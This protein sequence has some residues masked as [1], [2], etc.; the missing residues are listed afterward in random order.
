VSQTAI[1]YDQLL[2]ENPAAC[3]DANTRRVVSTCCFGAVS[4]PGS[5]RDTPNSREICPLAATRVN[6]ASS[7]DIAP[8]ITL[9]FEGTIHLSVLVYVSE[10]NVVVDKLGDKCYDVR[11][12]I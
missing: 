12:D 10:V 6:I 2:A 5:S 4:L 8:S 11:R 1:Y 3:L 7:V 9:S